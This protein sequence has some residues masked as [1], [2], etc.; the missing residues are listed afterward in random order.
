MKRTQKK[1]GTAKT[2]LRDDIINIAL[3]TAT[4]LFLL[5]FASKAQADDAPTKHRIA[6]L[7]RLLAEQLCALNTKQQASPRSTL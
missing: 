2:S 3:V 7:D 4:A 1:I 5:V 6:V